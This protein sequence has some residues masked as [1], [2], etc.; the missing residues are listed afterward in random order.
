MICSNVLVENTLLK[1]VM[2]LAA[3]IGA[4]TSAIM[5]VAGD[6]YIADPLLWRRCSLTGGQLNSR[7]RAL[8]ARRKPPFSRGPRTPVRR[9]KI[10]EELFPLS[11]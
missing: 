8:I 2:I 5:M 6:R 1:S 9:C 10:H 7:P 3:F 11:E 4:E